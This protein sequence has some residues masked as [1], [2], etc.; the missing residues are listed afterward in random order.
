MPEGPIIII[1]KEKVEKLNLPG[2]RLLE[3]SGDG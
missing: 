3:I 1:L 2:Q